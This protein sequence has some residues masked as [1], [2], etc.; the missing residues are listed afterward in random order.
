MFGVSGF[1]G[2]SG[3]VEDA[4]VRAILQVDL[5]GQRRGDDPAPLK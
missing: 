1:Y 5:F 3:D 2:G 4:G